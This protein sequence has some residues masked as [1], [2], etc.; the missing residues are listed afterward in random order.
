VAF[1][2]PDLPVFRFTESPPFGHLFGKRALRAI[3]IVL[4]A[5]ILV[6][7]K[8]A[9]LVRDSFQELRAPRVIS[10]KASA[11]SFEAPV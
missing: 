1:S 5:E 10:E 8:Q 7:L 6:N 9:L 11:R 4:H 3:G 2:T